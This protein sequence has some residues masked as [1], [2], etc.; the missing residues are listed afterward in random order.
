MYNT[1]RRKVKTVELL[2]GGLSV[3]A[4]ITDTTYVYINHQIV[5]FGD[6][7]NVRPS[8]SIPSLLLRCGV[9]VLA[10]VKTVHWEDAGFLKL[11]KCCTHACN[12][13]SKSSLYNKVVALH[14][15]VT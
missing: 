8:G 15:I 9:H 4:C 7:S 5:Y 2:R 13:N 14:K 11:Y 1:S 3:E 6:F 10:R 12:F